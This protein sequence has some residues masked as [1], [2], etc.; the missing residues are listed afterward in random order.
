MGLSIC[1]SICLGKIPRPLRAI[2]PRRDQAGRASV[3]TSGRRT[4]DASS[5]RHPFNAI[6]PGPVDTVLLK[7]LTDEW[8]AA[9]RAELP[10]GRF[11]GPEEIAPTAVILAS[12]DGSYYVGA[13]LMPAGGDV[14]V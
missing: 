7:N 8:R 1:L 5:R 13:T 11:A 9:K 14:M 2:F 3:V 10:I 12:E 4:R 6:A